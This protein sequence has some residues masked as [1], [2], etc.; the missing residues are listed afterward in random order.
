MIYTVTVNPAIDYIMHITEL[1]TGKINRSF[2]ENPVLGGKGI[3]VSL[4]LK[5]LGN[6]SVATGFTAGFTGRAV[7]Q[8]LNKAD[9]ENDFVE[10][11]QGLTR[12]NVKLRSEY[13]TDINAKGPE[14]S[15]EDIKALSEKLSRLKSGDWLILAGNVPSSL[16]DGTYAELI[17]SL[18]DKEIRTVVDATG[19][20]LMKT[21]KYR[22]FLIKP[23]EDELFELFGTDSG[24]KEDAVKHAKELKTLGARN[25]L[26]S[27]GSKGAVLIDEYGKTRFAEAI[28]GK[29]VNTVGAG[30]SM[31]AGFISGF[32]KTN[33]Y[34]YSLKL[35]TAAGAAT[36]FSEGI[37]DRE[38]IMR[39]EKEIG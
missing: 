35:G 3:N 36:A 38:L 21:L 5:E 8:G 1:K 30:D 10:L 26:V 13:E 14:I 33:D 37:A 16:P 27:M 28:K 9:I 22:P 19:E 17:A 31:V 32:I 24:T 2:D 29:T 11:P 20:Q 23:N 39:L 6:P 7:I 4:V 15:R 12:I 25:V 34:G 18:K